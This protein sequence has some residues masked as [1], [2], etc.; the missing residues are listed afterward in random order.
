MTAEVVRAIDGRELDELD[1]A[2]ALEDLGLE[3]PDEV[4][5]L[6]MKPILHDL[7]CRKDELRSVILASVLC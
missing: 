3:Q 4:R 6:H 1:A 7:V 5:Y 2:E